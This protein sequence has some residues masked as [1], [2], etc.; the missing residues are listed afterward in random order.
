MFFLIKCNYRKDKKELSITLIEWPPLTTLIAGLLQQYL[1]QIK[2]K[3]ILTAMF[4]AFNSKQYKN[5]HQHVR[6]QNTIYLL[7]SDMI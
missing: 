7:I 6:T 3:E 5:C 4:I 2:Q 1:V